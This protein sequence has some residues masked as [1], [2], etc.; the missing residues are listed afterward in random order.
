MLPQVVKLDIDNVALESQ[1][2][3]QIRGDPVAKSMIAE[4]HFEMHVSVWVGA[5]RQAPQGGLTVLAQ[6]GW[7]RVFRLQHVSPVPPAGV[8]WCMHC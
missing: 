7:S 3:D 4:M 2:I 8:M 1:L 5:V 6:L